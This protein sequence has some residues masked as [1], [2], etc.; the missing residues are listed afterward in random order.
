MTGNPERDDGPTP[1]GGTYTFDE[2]TMRSLI[3]DWHE[4]ADSY[5]TSQRN[6]RLMA[7]IE[8]PGEDPASVSHAIVASRSGRSYLEYLQANE[9]YCVE[10]AQL[11]QAALNE[12]LA[13]EDANVANFRSVGTDGPRSRT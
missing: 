3:K 13:I 1:N 6:A 12:Y 5:R 10:Q 2:E 8:P 4:L 7:D 11:F 9:E